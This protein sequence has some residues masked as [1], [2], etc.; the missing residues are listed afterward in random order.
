MESDLIKKRG[1]DINSLTSADFSTFFSS[2]V[3]RLIMDI[4][5]SGCHDLRIPDNIKPCTDCFFLAPVTEPEV[6]SAILSLKNTS[7]TD[8][9]EINSR[10][11]KHTIG[12]LAPL[13]TEL[14][15]RCISDDTFPDAFKIARIVPV[16]KSGDTRDASNYRP[17][18]ITTLFG[19]IF[20]LILKERLVKYFVKHSLFNGRQFGF[21]KGKSTISALLYL[22]E[23]VV[24]GFDGDD[25]TG[26]VLCDL[27]KA[28]DCVS[29]ELLLKKMERYGIRGKPQKFFRSYLEG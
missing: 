21:M 8:A 14:F 1:I 6:G 15:N 7:S 10:I 20:E 12:I 16:F 29:H 4:P 19:K 18:A 13:L 28:F 25:M 27:S 26:A 23:S 17:I 3:D 2:V 22:I 9:F 24:E 5:D 11:T